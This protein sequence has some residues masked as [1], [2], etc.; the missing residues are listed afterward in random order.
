MIRKLIKYYL[1]AETF[2]RIFAL[3]YSVFTM[4]FTLPFV[5]YISA[6][7]LAAFGAYIFVRERLAVQKITDY[8]I[9]FVV[10]AVLLIINLGYCASSIFYSLDVID[11]VFIGTV[12]S[13]II[14]VLAAVYIYKQIKSAE[15]SKNIIAAE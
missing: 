8:L 2:V 7:L 1:N 4:S 6:F 15:I 12:P 13:V 14:S 3:V 10:E 11:V 5:T 9:Y